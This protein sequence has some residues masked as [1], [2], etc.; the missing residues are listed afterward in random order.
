M[1]TLVLVLRHSIVKRSIMLRPASTAFC[2]ERPL[3]IKHI[4]HF[5]S[6]PCAV[7]FDVFVVVEL[8]RCIGV[9]A[10]GDSGNVRLVK[11]QSLK[12]GWPNSGERAIKIVRYKTSLLTVT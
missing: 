7:P 9:F 5:S 1:I 8:N 3:L 2:E 10:W 4:Y 11:G 12:L 6:Y